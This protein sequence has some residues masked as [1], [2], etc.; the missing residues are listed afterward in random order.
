[1]IRHLVFLFACCLL[2]QSVLAQPDTW[3]FTSAQNQE[4]NDMVTNINLPSL[5]WRAAV[6]QRMVQE[7]NWTADRLHLPTKYP[8]QIRDV[9]YDYIPRPWFSVIHATEPPYLPVSVYGTNIFNPSIPRD[10]RLRALEFGPMGQIETTNFGFYFYAGKLRRVMRLSAHEVERYARDLDQLVGQPSIIDNNGAY[11]LATQWLAA[12]DMD[13][14]ALNKQ[15]WVVHQLR[16]LPRE[17]TNSVLLPLYYVDFGNKHF[18]ASGNL[19]AFDEPLVSVEILG[20]T[21]ELQDLTINDPSFSRRPL[22]LIT[23]ALDLVQRP[24][25]LVKRLQAP[26]GIQ[27]NS[28]AR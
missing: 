3:K 6:I 21:K 16:Y 19:H 4:M 15:K 9:V 22:L 7:A 2:A 14:A 27:T 10:A 17:A 12:V 1:M 8:I 18:P 24:N 26:L 13:M 23:N 11:Q 28:T 25:P 20:T 5:T